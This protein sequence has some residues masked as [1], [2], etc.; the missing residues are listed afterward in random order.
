MREREREMGRDVDV[1]IGGKLGRDI[2]KRGREEL[3]GCRRRKAHG[4]RGSGI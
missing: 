2:R 4:V 1:E 3:D